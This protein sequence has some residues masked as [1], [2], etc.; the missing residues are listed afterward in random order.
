MQVNFWMKR[1]RELS[2]QVPF[3]LTLLFNDQRFLALF[4]GK[5]QTRSTKALSFSFTSLKMGK[6]RS[7]SA[8][9]RVIMQPCESRLK[10]CPPIRLAFK[11]VRNLPV[12]LGFFTKIGFLGTIFF[13]LKKI[14]VLKSCY[15]ASRHCLLSKKKK[16]RS[17]EGVDHHVD[18]V[19]KSP[20]NE[21]YATRSSEVVV[22]LQSRT[23][24]LS[25]KPR[26]RSLFEVGWNLKYYFFCLGD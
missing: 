9:W 14:V 22:S 3:T 2:S 21:A 13:A 1:E 5:G 18:L 11:I 20:E 4:F 23:A 19:F 15:W 26:R 16:K 24:V 10:N 7:A 6:R 12:G 8:L 25:L 17:S